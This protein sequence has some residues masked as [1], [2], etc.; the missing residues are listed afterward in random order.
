MASKSQEMTAVLTV[1]VVVTASLAGLYYYRYNQASAQ[2]ASD[3]QGLKAAQQQYAG[4]GRDYSTLLQ[5]YNESLGL[6]TA[7]IAQM[8]TSTEAYR[9]ASARLPGLWH[10]YQLLASTSVSLPSTSILID[11]GNG[12]G[13]WYNETV[14][15]G[16]NLYV[17]TLVATNGSMAATWYP[18]YGE[19]FVTGIL[20][21]NN[22]YS[23]YWFLWQYN[24]T[25]WS[26]AQVGADDLYATNGSV[27]A[28]TFCTADANFNPQCSP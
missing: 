14:Q 26:V 21:V 27:Y 19:H 15:P 6:L 4:L 10:A 12:S 25:S 28:W 22:T 8:N 2:D 18:Q 7:S 3:L 20:G 1:V 23:R 9:Q 17:A 24:G 11:I 16:W 13:A 5:N